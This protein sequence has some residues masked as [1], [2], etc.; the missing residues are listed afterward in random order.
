VLVAIKVRP[1]GQR[2]DLLD[3]AANGAL[4][5]EIG[6]RVGDLTLLV[7]PELISPDMSIHVRVRSVKGPITVSVLAWSSALVDD[8]A[9]PQDERWTAIGDPCTGADTLV[10]DDTFQP[11]PRAH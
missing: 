7:K 11:F 8:P 1:S 9:T 2:Y 10:I 5:T 6:P 4:I 3:A